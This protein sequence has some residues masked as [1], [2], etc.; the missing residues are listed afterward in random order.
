MEKNLMKRALHN[1][2]LLAVILY[3]IAGT[4]SIFSAT[5]W[6]ANQHFETMGE[7]TLNLA[8]IA[9][10]SIKVTD[11]QLHKMENISFQDLLSNENNQEL[12]RLFKENGLA[13]NVKYAYVVRKLDADQVKYFVD[14]LDA[15]FYDMP[16]G[17]PL[18]WVWLM[19]VIVN[20][21]EQ[22]LVDLDEE[23][24]KDKN[25]YTHIEE[26]TAILYDQQKSGYFINND[27]WGSQISAM[28]PVYTE[29]GSYIGLLGVDVYSSDFYKFRAKLILA[30]LLLV[31]IPTII[32]SVIYVFFHLRYK[33]EMRKVA[34][35]DKMTGLYTRAYYDD[36]IRRQVKKLRRA[37]DSITVVMIDVDEFKAYNDYYGH[38][39]GDEVIKAIGDTIRIESGKFDD[40]CPGRYGGDEFI[41]FISNLSEEQGD[42]FCESLRKKVEDLNLLH[43]IRKDIKLVTVSLGIYTSTKKDF[44]LEPQLLIEKADKAL[45]IAK[46]AGRN[47]MQRY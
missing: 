18:D 9:A 29:E 16:V 12:S 45:Y 23:Y 26:N 3:I 19:D 28:V 25:R 8:V 11:E 20:E 39:K 31:L 34:F 13:E 1:Y 27:E 38:T 41:I 46:R 32:M 30:L 4:A 10:N 7:T 5:R 47:C 35:L 24:Y 21:E 42:Q 15:E 33:E 37:E 2:L 22:K 17:T 14:N 36:Y 44:P 43:E 6:V 40:V